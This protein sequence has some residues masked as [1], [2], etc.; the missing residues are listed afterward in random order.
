MRIAPRF[1]AGIWVWAA[2][3]V[4]VVGHGVWAQD[5]SAQDGSTAKT[6]AK[7]D[8]QAITELHEQ[9][10]DLY[11][12]GK[13]D[14]ALALWVRILQSDPRDTTALYN[15]ACAVTKLGYTDEAFKLLEAAIHCGFVNFEHLKRDP[16]LAPLREDER[17]GTLLASVETMYSQAADHMEAWA[18]EMLGPDAIIER[19]EAMRIVYATDIDQDTFDQMK[20]SLEAQVRMQ[21]ESFFGAAPN[22]FVLLVVPSPATADELIGSVRIG[23]FYDH[24][25]RRL[26]MRDI[27]PSLRH[28]ITHALHHAQMDRL[29]QDHPMWIQEGLAS[30][31]EM[32]EL[33][34]AG[35]YRVLDNTRINIA[36]N[37]QRSAALT[38]WEDLFAQDDRKFTKQKSRAKYAQARAVFQ[39]LAEEGRLEE[40]YQV[41]VEKYAEDRTGLLAFRTVYGE[42]IDDIERRW[43]LWL[44][45]KEKV[46]EQVPEERPALGVWIADQAAND[47]V[48]IVGLHPGGAAKAA[49]VRSREVIT[50]IDGV[51]VYVVEEVVAE[52][53]KRGEGA[54]VK[55]T[56]KRGKI[57]REVEIELAPV[58]V[59]RRRPIVQEPGVAA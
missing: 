46:L 59:N 47:G 24:D 51:A 7:L 9:A 52:I 13:T 31:F 19:S 17:F 16:D 45:E 55:V 3:A 54:I 29:E 43:R 58:R 11:T 25:T 36:I 2:A 41:Y 10:V 49:G 12:D 15:S 23:G 18:R 22:S 1:M 33:D 39:F 28:E 6:Q 4:L 56:L 38:S 35:R 21:I 44:R 40:W 53:L 50:A 8:E 42:E 30:M 57:S 5:G 26:V 20:R 32:Y 27:G 14:D 37:L 48:Q 34:E